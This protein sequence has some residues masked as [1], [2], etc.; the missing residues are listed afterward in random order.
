MAI[1]KNLQ[2]IN[3]GKGEEKR[4]PSDL[5]GGTV[6]WHSHYGERYGCSF[7]N[8]E[9]SYDP[10]IPL[11]GIYPEKDMSK[12]IHAPQ[13]ESINSSALSLLYGPTLTSVMTTGKTTTLTIQTFVG[14]VISLFFN[15]LF[16]VA[17]MGKNLTA[18]QETWAQSLSQE[19]PWR[20][21]WLPTPVL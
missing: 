11:L 16:S 10:A 20:K 9:L 1:I 14:K 5:V 12:R 7:K 13:F 15:T 4:E 8:L 19:G 21:E 17:Q 6:N 18:V 2:T 3:A